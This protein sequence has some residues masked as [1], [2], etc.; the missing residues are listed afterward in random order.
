[1]RTCFLCKSTEDQHEIVESYGEWG[2]SDCIEEAIAIG[3]EQEREMREMMSHHGEYERDYQR[4]YTRACLYCG[5]GASPGTE[6][7]SSSCVAKF[8]DGDWD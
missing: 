2:H 6:F 5:E 7:C 1:M 4:G 3:Q 8:T